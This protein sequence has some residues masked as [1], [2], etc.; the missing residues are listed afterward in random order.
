[1][2]WFACAASSVGANIF[3]RYYEGFE[4]TR[5]C[6][7]CGQRSHVWHQFRPGRID[8]K[9][10]LAMDCWFQKLVFQVFLDFTDSD[11]IEIHTRP[12]EEDYQ[13]CQ[14]RFW[15]GKDNGAIYLL[16]PY[17]V[18]PA[19]NLTTFSLQ[20]P[21]AFPGVSV[22]NRLTVAAKWIQNCASHAECRESMISD[23]LAPS[24]LLDLSESY[25]T[26][27]VK[28]VDARSLKAQYAA[29]SYCWGDSLP[30]TT[31]KATIQYMMEGVQLQDLPLTFKDATNVCHYLG[32]RYIWIDSVCIIQDD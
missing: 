18:A 8:P 12:L 21:A 19:T 25:T 20:L 28:I 29:L 9:A 7:F 11:D 15:A 22:E 26:G 3:A 17:N 23:N 13:F 24:R 5:Y 4:E 30:L 6:K 1:M 10:V 32:I 14:L 2:P 27:L 16:G 31:T